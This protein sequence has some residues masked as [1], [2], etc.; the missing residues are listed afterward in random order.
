MN[1]KNKNLPETTSQPHA[2]SQALNITNPA[3]L[4]QK[5]CQE[6]ENREKPL[7]QNTGGNS[8]V[9]QSF[10][11]SS[12]ALNFLLPCPTIRVLTS[13]QI[14]CKICSL[15]HIRLPN[16]TLYLSPNVIN[17]RTPGQLANNTFEDLTNTRPFYQNLFPS[18]RKGNK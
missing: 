14:F 13:Q 9:I 8:P 17:N 5:P 7:D 12:E 4:K 6:S 11:S 18:R 3:K 10:S 16:F 1:Y 2:N 15:V